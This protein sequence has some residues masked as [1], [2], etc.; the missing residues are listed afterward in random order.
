MRKGETCLRQESDECLFTLR[1]I[2]MSHPTCNNITLGGAI[3]CFTS[4]CLLGL[5]GRFIDEEHFSYLCTARAWM[6][7]LGFSLAY[8]SMF[9]KIWRVHRLTTKA[10]RESKVSDKVNSCRLSI[11]LLRLYTFHSCFRVELY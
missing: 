1:M 9:S 5:D 4:V 2:K 8:G 10:K 3:M 7:S 6:L 11:P